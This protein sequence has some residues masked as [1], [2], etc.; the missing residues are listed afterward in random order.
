MIYHLEEEIYLF[1]NASNGQNAEE[2]LVYSK[3][4]A[5]ATNQ[6]SQ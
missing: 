5:S 6:G 3:K 1:Q 4:H 2:N